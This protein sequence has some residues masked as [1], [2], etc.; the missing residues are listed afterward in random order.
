M[1]TINWEILSCFS[2]MLRSN[3]SS[4]LLPTDMV[5]DI[6]SYLPVK[7]LLRFKSVCSN[8]NGIT[9]DFRFI[10]LHYKRVPVFIGKKLPQSDEFKLLSSSG[11]VLEYATRPS[12]LPPSPN[13]RY[14]VRNPEMDHQILDI[15]DP[16][17]PILNLCLFVDPNRQLLKLLSLVYDESLGDQVLGYEVLDLRSEESGTYSW[18][19]INLPQQC[20]GETRMC[21]LVKRHTNQTIVVIASGA[22]YSIWDAEAYSCIGIDILDMV[23]DTYIGH[24]TLSTSFYK[25]EDCMYWNG[26]LS[27]AKIVKEELHVLVLDVYKKKQIKWADEKLIIKLPFLKELSVVPQIKLSYVTNTNDLYFLWRD[28][29]SVC[30]FDMRMGKLTTLKSNYKEPQVVHIFGPCLFAF[31]GMQSSS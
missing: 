11:L 20:R 24:T 15:P 1:S 17:K 7:S 30:R 13:L 9:Q 18:R 25:K 23:N 10:C 26:K 4:V 8:W 14:R 29:E 12:H 6:L 21:E 27:F 16:E 19:P 5:F 22:A 28:K 2:G 3:N 31:K